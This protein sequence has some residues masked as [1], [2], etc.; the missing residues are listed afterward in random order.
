MFES[1]RDYRLYLEDIAMECKRIRKFTNGLDYNAFTEN[2]EKVYA[3]AKA[4]ENIGEG[5]K[6]LPKP[7]TDAYPDIP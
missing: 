6:Q 4:L 3:V 1:K 2:I 5:V 7:L